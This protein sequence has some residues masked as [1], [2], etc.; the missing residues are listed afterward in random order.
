MH[1]SSSSPLVYIGRMETVTEITI[2][3]PAERIFA[4]AVATEDWPRLLPHY[5]FVRRLK[6]AADHKLV[7]M[8]ARRNL[9]LFDYPVRW[10]AEQHNYPDENRITFTHRRG[11]SRGMN[12]EWQLVER[13]GRTHVRI[14]HEFHS[15]LPLIGGFFARRI[16]GDIFV[17][18]IAGQTLARLKQIAERGE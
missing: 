13:D 16:V 8:A 1:Q 6:G 18:Y 12:V 7:R 11:I 17:G 3:A 15:N 5:D 2:R 14:W 10:T 4:L 9:Y